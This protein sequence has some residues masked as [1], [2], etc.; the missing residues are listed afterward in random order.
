MGSGEQG[1]EETAETSSDEESQVGA[2]DAATPGDTGEVDNSAQEDSV[3]EE[4]PRPPDPRDLRIRLLEKQLVENEVRLRDYIKAH[5]KAQSEFDG[6]RQRLRRDQEEQI[7]IAKGKV[8]E[9]FLDV[10]DNLERSIQAARSGG[11]LTSLLDGVE[12]VHKMFDQALEELGLEKHAP[13]GD[14]FDPM[15]MEAHGMIPVSDPEQANKVMNIL[16]PGY[17]LKGRE[18]RPALVQVGFHSG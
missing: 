15:S 11:T 18:L 1:N 3:E 6:L 17:R 13:L 5:K 14:A 10:A 12:L 4:A 9:R 7:D 8:V 2:D 16:R